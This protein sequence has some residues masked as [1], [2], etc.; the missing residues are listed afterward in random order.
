MLID[1][2]GRLF[3]KINLLDIFFVLILI[4]A[5]FGVYFFL[6]GHGGSAA[7]MPVTY[8][9][10]VQKQNQVY[11]DHIIQ[12]E[13]VTDGVTKAFMGTIAGLKTEPAKVVTPANDKIVLA[14]PEGKLDGYITIKADATVNYPDLVLDGETIKIGKEV[15]LRSESAAMRGYIVDIKY[16]SEQFRRMK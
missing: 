9:V 1:E 16:D 11:F 8:T 4:V 2:K 15:A 12:G 6:S 3:G 10:E 14:Q 13:R 5:L 7:T